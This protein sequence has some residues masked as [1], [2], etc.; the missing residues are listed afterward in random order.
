MAISG[1]ACPSGLK[2]QQI[3]PGGCGA[4]N[5]DSVYCVNNV[6]T[7]IPNE[8]TNPALACVLK[9]DG[10]TYAPNGGKT[11]AQLGRDV[12]NACTGECTACPVGTT[13]SGREVGVCKTYGER[14]LEIL[15]DGLAILGGPNSDGRYDYSVTGPVAINGIYVKSDASE[16]LNWKSATLPPELKWLLKN[17]TLCTAD[18]D[19][20][21]GKLCSEGGYCYKSGISV[22]TA[23]AVNSSDCDKNQVCDM[24]SKK[25][26]VS[27]DPLKIVKDASDSN[28][29][30]IYDSSLANIGSAVYQ[31]ISGSVGIGTTSPNTSALLDLTSTTKGLLLPRMTTSQ[32]N[33]ISSA[34]AGLVVYDSSLNKLYYR[35]NSTWTD[36]TGPQG[37]QGYTGATGPTGAT[38]AT[39]SQGPA[40][41]Q[42]P[43][44]GIYDSLGLP[45]TGPRV[46]GDAGGR[47]LFN[48]GN[49]AIGTST[50]ASNS[51]LTVY[52]RNS[53]VNT[54]ISLDVQNASSVNIGI[55]GNINSTTYNN[56][57]A[58]GIS[59]DILSNNNATGASFNVNSFSA[60]SGYPGMISD[61]RGVTTTTVNS[62]GNAYGGYFTGRAYGSIGWGMGVYAEGY[63]QGNWP[64]YGVYAK[65]E[66]QSNASNAYGVYAT[67]VGPAT[68][69]YGF[70][71]PDNSYVGG[72]L[73]VGGTIYGTVSPSDIRLKE[74]VSELDDDY[75]LNIISK[76]DPVS[77]NWKDKS[78]G[79]AKQYGF[80]AQAVQKILPDLVK[81]SP[82]DGML[83]LNYD[84]LIAP[85]V[86][87]IQEQQKEI[88][89]LKKQ[90]DDLQSVNDSL[91]SRVKALEDKMNLK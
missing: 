25:C 15:S 32:K 63:G 44:L 87:A 82:S 49:A 43:T 38:G 65:A 84:G 76:L 67:A 66:G 47:N 2:R 21:G 80:I 42:G 54:G 29:L 27:S 11:C 19:C 56:A 86:K 1:V 36:L 79:E 57:H 55:L 20:G 85:I 22:G 81:A 23:C 89:N 35:N 52:G 45:S 5:E 41:P 70:Y 90:N 73:T 75:G 59:L 12:A 24:T 14:F 60:P 37:P 17:Y 64:V 6:P 72:N 31:N 7:P 48:L 18:S 71:T 78:Y 51:K 10:S 13:P 58:K 91:E 88:E 61:N 53:I 34:P 16:N 9:K 26:V 69:R 74:N 83:G 39:G 77:F 28:L 33:A 30:K 3:C 62:Y 68:N 40:G 46:A 50:L 4:C 8:L